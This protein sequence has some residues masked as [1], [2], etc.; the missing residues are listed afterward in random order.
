[1]LL[2]K[3]A[4]IECLDQS[5]ESPLLWALRACTSGLRERVTRSHGAV[6]TNGTG[7]TNA[8][9]LLKAGCDPNAKDRYRCTPLMSATVHGKVRVIAALL[10]SLR[11]D[12]DALDDCGRSA[13]S[14]DQRAKY[15][16]DILGILSQCSDKISSL[17]ESI[18][19][20]D[21]YQGGMACDVWQIYIDGD[22]AYYR[23]STCNNYQFAICDDCKARGIMCLNGSHEMRQFEQDRFGLTTCI[24][25][26]VDF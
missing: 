10:E 8:V 26:A 12:Q 19:R 9:A 20:M 11:I 23:C 2:A 4:S 21:G 6:I 7:D 14:E 3:G 25:L 22:G 15:F 5:D 24:V 1:M 16:H 18:L 17:P 13:F